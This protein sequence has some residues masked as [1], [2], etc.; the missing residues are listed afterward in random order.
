MSFLRLYEWAVPGKKLE[1]RRNKWSTEKENKIIEYD[2][3]E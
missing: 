3:E 1:D 2:K